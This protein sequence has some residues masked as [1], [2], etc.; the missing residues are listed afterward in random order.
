W[1]HPLAWSLDRAARSECEQACDD[2]VLDAGTRPSEYADHLLGIARLLP[3]RDPFG[4]VTLAMSRRSQLEGRLLSILHPHA[5]RDAVSRRA[6]LF[7][8]LVA[9][10][11]VVPVAALRL[12]AQPVGGVEKGV[13]GG[14]A[15]GV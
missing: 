1:F 7:S 4:A 14:V 8:A 9:M 10:L 2:L 15:G 6:V 11:F 13:K 12:T 5:R 3:R